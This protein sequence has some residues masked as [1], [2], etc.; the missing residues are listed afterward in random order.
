MRH[1]VLAFLVACSG[2]SKPAVPVPPTTAEPAPPPV[3]DAP[4]PAVEVPLPTGEVLA[5]D[6]PKTTVA[7]NTFTA[8]AGWQIVVRG[9]ATILT[10]PEGDSHIA[11]VDVQ[12]KDAD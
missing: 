10:P 5:A 4:K 11:L 6:T 3:A 9:P 7:G 8:P 12:A 2:S 1:C